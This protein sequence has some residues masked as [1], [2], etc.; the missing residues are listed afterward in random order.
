MPGQPQ[1]A[2]AANLALYSKNHPHIIREVIE[3]FEIP[4]SALG[5]KAGLV[6]MKEDK[7]IK[8]NFVPT[9]LA[10][11][12]EDYVDLQGKLTKSVL[13]KLAKFHSNNPEYFTENSL[14]TTKEF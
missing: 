9:T 8:L 13:K 2:T 14:K 3:Y 10:A 11:I 12:L 6:K 5:L 7:K 4:E 1:Y